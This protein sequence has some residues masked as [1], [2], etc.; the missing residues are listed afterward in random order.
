MQRIRDKS[1]TLCKQL[2]LSIFQQFRKLIP[3]GYCFGNVYLFM[4]DMDENKQ[5]LCYLNPEWFDLQAYFKDRKL[6]GK[7]E[8]PANRYSI[9]KASN[10]QIIKEHPLL[11]TKPKLT[12][13]SS[14]YYYYYYYSLCY[15]EHVSPF[16]GI[17]MISCPGGMWRIMNGNAFKTIKQTLR[18]PG[19]QICSSTRRLR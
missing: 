16:L 13:H 12:G 15:P 9:S 5:Y 4:N 3:S 19:S 1:A 17:W 18:A 8:L 7:A 11:M 2:Q 6:N 14:F 10:Q